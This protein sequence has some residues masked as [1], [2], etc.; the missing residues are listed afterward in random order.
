[1]NGSAVESITSALTF[2][3]SPFSAW[4]TTAFAHARLTTTC[5]ETFESV[6]V[7]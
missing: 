7:P 5:G 4:S 6:S 2:S 3:S 1:V